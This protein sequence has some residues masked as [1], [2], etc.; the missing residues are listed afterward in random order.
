MSQVNYRAGGEVPSMLTCPIFPPQ[1]W[2]SDTCT[3]DD[4]LEL[5][6]CPSHKKTPVV[7][8]F[9]IPQS[10][11]DKAIGF[12]WTCCTPEEGFE[13]PTTAE[14]Y[15]GA[16]M[17]LPDIGH[18]FPIRPRTFA[19]GRGQSQHILRIRKL[20]PLAMQMNLQSLHKRNILHSAHRSDV[21]ITLFH[22]FCL[23]LFLLSLLCPGYLLVFESGCHLLF[24]GL[25]VNPVALCGLKEIIRL[26]THI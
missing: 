6:E 4:L 18:F 13:F 17:G 12:P 26:F 24:D 3:V 20:K 8:L 1:R 22:G 23:F 10:L 5:G 16:G 11:H 9:N 2:I 14:F 19:Q 15:L 7:R 21:A 25:V